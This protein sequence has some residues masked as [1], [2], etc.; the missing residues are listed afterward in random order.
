MFFK[1]WIADLLCD[2]NI[3]LLFM[4]PKEIKLA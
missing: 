1:K 3:L 2:T 4:Y